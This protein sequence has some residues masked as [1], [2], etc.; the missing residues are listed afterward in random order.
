[1][2]AQKMISADTFTSRPNVLSET[3]KVD[4]QPD[5]LENYN[6]FNSDQALALGLVDESV[7][8]EEVMARAPS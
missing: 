7:E 4:N 8:V 1:M 3:H 2:N 6:V 5:A